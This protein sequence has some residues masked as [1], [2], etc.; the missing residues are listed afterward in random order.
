MFNWVGRG[1]DDRASGPALSPPA[2]PGDVAASKVLSK[3]L[4]AFSGR[5]APLLVDLGPVV[6]ANVEFFG[7][8]LACKIHVLD[9]FVEVEAHARRGSSEGLADALAD[10][11]TL[12]YDSADGILCWNL[13]DFLDK[14]T[15]QSLASH[16]TR[17]LRSGG[18]LHAFFG[19]SA[20]DL[21]HYT[22][23]VVE[24]EQAFRLRPYPATAVRRLVLANRDIARMF[25]GLAVKES[26][27]LKSNTRET[28]FR[29]P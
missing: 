14:P 4:A 16:L 19:T 20:L 17:L 8:R 9:L 12:P 15:G 28:L 11:L 2:S 21:T 6:G 18:A 22:R 1:R 24:D 27:L 3:F 5:S 13:F 7:D 25:E 10:R 23:F 26:V 29:K